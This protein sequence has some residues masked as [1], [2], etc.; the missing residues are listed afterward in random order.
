VSIIGGTSYWYSTAINSP[1]SLDDNV[2]VFEVSSGDNTEIVASKLLEK[3]LIGNKYAFLI[4]GKLNKELAN[5][6]QAGYFDLSPS[7]S[8]ID[9]YQKLQKARTIDDIRVSI[10]EGLRYDEIASILDNAFANIDNAKFN[11]NEFISI[12]ENPDTVEFK[13]VIKAF[14]QKHKP[15]GLS[16]EGY[17]FPETYFFSKDASSLQ[18]TER[19]IETLIGKLY[20]EDLQ[21][22]A[23]SDYSLHDILNI[24]GMIE[25]EAFADSEMPMIADVIYKRLEKGINGIKLLQIDATLL[26]I[27]KDWKANPVPLKRSESPYNT[28]KF[29]GLPP[30]PISNPGIASIRG[31]IYP[32]SNDYYYYIHDKTGKIHFAKTLSE[33]NANVNKYLR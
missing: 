31:A 28:Y 22:I 20:P 7:M 1:I 24:A 18:V 4:Y 21:T 2:I 8:I 19:L 5:G 25:R 29:P 26:Y 3:E 15:N 6:I 23:S 30:G 33:H 9:I 13:P 16:L 11:K 32:K 12:A 17:L 10:P 14:L 27:N